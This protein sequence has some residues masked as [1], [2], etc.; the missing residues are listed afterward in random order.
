MG[1]LAFMVN[2]AKRAELYWGPLSDSSV[3]GIP[4]P[5]QTSFRREMTL[6]ALH[7]AKS[8]R[9]VPTICHGLVGNE[10]ALSDVCD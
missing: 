1:E 8:N 10:V 6:A 3:S 2:S 9:S 7:C 5:E 4:C